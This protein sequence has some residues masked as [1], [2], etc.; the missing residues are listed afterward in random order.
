MR[1]HLETH[2]Q[3][4]GRGGDPLSR[5]SKKR[6]YFPPDRPEGEEDRYRKVG[7]PARVHSTP[8]HPHRRKSDQ[9]THLSKG[10]G[11]PLPSRSLSPDRWLLLKTKYSPVEPNHLGRSDHLPLT[12]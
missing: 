6:G 8:F 9:K 5:L 7:R 12:R 10:C 3:S 4:L 11:K 1:R 2:R